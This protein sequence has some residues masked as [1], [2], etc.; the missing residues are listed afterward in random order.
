M[1]L[2]R[3]ALNGT[4]KSLNF[5]SELAIIRCM[6]GNVTVGATQNLRWTQ[7]RV[8]TWEAVVSSLMARHAICQSCTRR[9]VAQRSASQR[10][11]YWTV[12]TVRLQQFTA[13]SIS[14]ALAAYI[15]TKCCLRYFI[16]EAT[17]VWRLGSV[18]SLMDTSF[19]MTCFKMSTNAFITQF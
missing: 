3:C 18:R 7:A 5:S 13:K 11:T 9:P 17:A 2:I 4:S 1:F 6:V 8:P 14:D 15:I 10:I 16:A 19:A 12:A